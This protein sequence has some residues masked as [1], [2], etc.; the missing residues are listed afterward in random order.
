M[1][2]DRADVIIPASLMFSVLLKFSLAK[3]I[4]ISMMGLRDG[5]LSEMPEE[6]LGDP[7]GGEYEEINHSAF[8]NA[9]RY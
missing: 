5:K 6:N 3:T 2:S 8:Y 9:R 1:S 4:A 7:S